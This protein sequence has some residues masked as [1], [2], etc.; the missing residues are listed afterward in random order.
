VAVV[1]AAL[2]SVAGLSG[3][4]LEPRRWG[5]LPLGTNFAGM[6]YIRTEGD[7]AFDPVL[8][9]E[10]VEV[11]MDTVALKYI[12]AYEMFCKSA[13]FDL[14]QAYQDGS[15]TGLFAGAPTRRPRPGARA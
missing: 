14:T 6:G 4:E 11:E 2:A 13:R 9:L 8:R 5:H 15:W 10:D 7:I 12:R 3:Q 1:I